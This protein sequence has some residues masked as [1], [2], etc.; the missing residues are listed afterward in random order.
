MEYIVQKGDGWERISKQTGISQ[1]ELKENN[2]K[3]AARGLWVGDKLKLPDTNNK[4]DES[5]D[6]SN[7]FHSWVNKI[8]DAAKPLLRNSESSKSEVV[9]PGVYYLTYPGHKINLNGQVPGI[10]KDR[11]MALGHAGI[12]IVDNN[13]KVTQYDYGRYSNG[14]GAV[15]ENRH[16]GNWTKTKR[17]TINIGKTT[18]GQLLNYLKEKGEHASPN[19]RLTYSPEVDASKV[20]E[21]IEYD[22][23]NL[24]RGTYGV[25]PFP[26]A[27]WK[28][29]FSGEQ[30]FGQTLEDMCTTR[31]CAKTAFDAIVAGYNKP[32]VSNTSF[33]D[34]FKELLS[35]EKDGPLAGISLSP[36]SK[37]RILQQNNFKTYDSND[38]D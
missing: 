11:Y 15:N 7:K 30:S 16:E 5:K 26:K 29:A 6:E 14:F 12:V 28:R 37:E 31:G 17:T 35:P 23:N 32:I 18:Y 38:Y 2:P 25:G 19:V 27:K 24:D 33:F 22:A 1:K 20:K 9:Q 21:Y 34:W 10:N 8:S 36:R 13:G 4:K 3:I